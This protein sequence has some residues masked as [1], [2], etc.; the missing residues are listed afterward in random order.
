MP[1]MK[2]ETEKING[3]DL[4]R[5]AAMAGPLLAWY[6]ENRRSLP[7]RDD[8]SAYHVWI[9]EIM[10]QQTR[11][12]TVKGYYERFLAELPD[13]R[14]LSEVEEEK[15]LKLWEG[16]GYYSRARNLKRAAE[17]I[18][19]GYGGRM[20]Q[21]YEELMKLPGIGSYTA[22]AIASIAFGKRTAAVDGNVLRV[23]ARVLAD[24]ADIGSESLKRLRKAQ[25]EAVMPEEEA[26]PGRFNQAL[27]DLGAM[28]CL[29]NGQ[30]KCGECPLK[31]DCLAHR[32]GRTQELPY[33]AAKQKRRI[34]DRTVFVVRYKDRILLHRRPG[35]GLLAGLYELPGTEG[36]LKKKAAL[37]FVGKLGFVPI[38]IEPLPESRHI[39]S[40]IEWRMKGY[41]VRADELAATALPS[42]G[43]V[44]DPAATALSSEGPVHDPA[45]TARTFGD[46][47]DGDDYILRTGE[48]IEERYPIP[49][50]FSAYAAY[51]KQKPYK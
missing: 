19:S 22:G 45:A 21:D 5:L 9:S 49:S 37:E 16:L 10:L 7:W 20:P 23:I 47:A 44:H 32:E 42:V 1:D 11:V 29:P 33:K 17:T 40:H 43:P 4:S 30:P 12:E 24:P 8:P 6:E 2:D 36:H 31:K 26:A 48:E 18:R 15:L 38:H 28:V 34:E 3:E 39:F 46:S 25:L 50:A 27:M 35:K 14:A 51:I 13:I 41:L